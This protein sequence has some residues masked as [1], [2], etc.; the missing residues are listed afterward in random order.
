MKEEKDVSALVRPADGFSLNIDPFSPTAFVYYRDKNDQAVSITRL[1]KSIQ[2]QPPA[3]NQKTVYHFTNKREE[4]I[5]SG[6]FRFYWQMRNNGGPPDEVLSKYWFTEADE[7]SNGGL[8]WRTHGLRWNTISLA[9]IT[10]TAC[11]FSGKKGSRDA[12]LMRQRFGRDII[13]INYVSFRNDIENYCSK[14]N[15]KLFVNKVTYQNSTPKD[16]YPLPTIGETVGEVGLEVSA[17]IDGLMKD[18]TCFNKTKEH[19]FEHELRFIFFDEYAT[20][21]PSTEYIEVPISQNSMRLLPQT[22]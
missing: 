13:E 1:N 2:N 17:I 9:Q 16:C 5:A 4:I 15:K 3:F 18:G 6:V 7:D 21:D 8:H 12:D 20:L 14:N 10:R 19:K 11:F 22:K